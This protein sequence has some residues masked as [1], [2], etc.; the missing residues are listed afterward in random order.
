MWM[1]GVRRGERAMA[2]GCSVSGVD[3]CAPPE[4]AR[5]RPAWSPAYGMHCDCW[6]GDGFGGAGV[7]SG[8]SQPWS[9]IPL[10]QDQYEIRVGC[11]DAMFRMLAWR[12]AGFP[13]YAPDESKSFAVRFV[14]VAAQSLP[15]PA[16]KVVR[17]WNIITR[18]DGAFTIAPVAPEGS[19]DNFTGLALS[20]VQPGWTN[21]AGQA[22]YNPLEL[23]PSTGENVFRIDVS[24]VATPAPTT[25]ASTTTSTSTSAATIVSN[26]SPPEVFITFAPSTDAP[27]T[28][29]PSTFAPTTFVPSTDA[30]STF[31]P[32][33]FVP[34]T[35]APAT[36]APTT[37]VPS[38]N[39]PA[40]STSAATIVSN[41]SPP[42][43]F[44]IVE[45]T[46]APTPEPTL[47]P[48]PEP[49]LAPTPEPT[50][51]PTLAPTPVPVLAA[52]AQS[53]A[54]TVAPLASNAGT[55]LGVAVSVVAVLAVVYLVTRKKKGTN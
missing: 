15:V 49:T 30:P 20:P 4:G 5:L 22:Y 29:A 28:D 54:T 48:T 44:I 18:E 39:A 31:A 32:T 26:T 38:T 23:A 36:F 24:E 9:I 14:D 3:V 21:S 52:G 6:R 51:A 17:A 1:N 47:A 25:S 7:I 8:G 43:V 10:Q 34:S 50:L 33:T 12:S 53:Q 27:S 42:E 35:N 40:T 19:T 41:T 11:G 16:D 46:L 13:N 55:I 2:F 37:F 45:P